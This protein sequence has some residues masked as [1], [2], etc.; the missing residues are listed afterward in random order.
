MVMPYV[1]GKTLAQWRAGESEVPPRTAAEIA[2]ELALAVA[3]AHE[4]GILHRDLKPGN[5]LLAPR[6]SVAVGDE[7][8]FIPRLTD[9][10]L[11]KSAN[12]DRQD[13]R[14]GSMIGTACYMSPEQA[15]GR[16][17][18]V[19]ARS[20]VYGLGAIL[21]EL[22][23]GVPPFREANQLR[24]IQKVLREDPPAFRS[25]KIKIPIDLEV[26]CLKCLEKAPSNRYASAQELADDLQSFLNGD[27]IR[28]RPITPIAR[29]GKWSRR[30]PTRAAMVAAGI[31]GV[32][33]LVGVSLW[34]NSRLTQLLKD[35]EFERQIARQHELE[36]R[37]RAYVT[38]VRNAKITGDQDNLGQMLKLLERHRPKD[39]EQDIRDF[40]W[41]H[42]WREFD[43]SSRQLGTHVEKA[44]SVAVTRKGDLAASGGA[45]SV[46]R[47]W[48]LPAGSLIA[49]LRGHE[50]GS[51]E[52]ISFSPNGER[53]VSA[54]ID[55][56]VRVWDM[57]TYQQLFVRGDH[58]LA[59][60]DAVYSPKGD[61][62]ASAGMDNT[63][64][65]WN[66]D[67]GESLGV[68]S[69]H[70][71]RV[72]CMAFHPTED[73]L[74]SGGGDATIRLWDWKSRCPD[75]RLEGG[76]I[77]IPDLEQ[78]PRA[79]VFEPN[80]KS[81]IAGVMKS[82]TVRFSLEK[83][84]YGNE[85][86]RRSERGN[87]LSLAWP[88]DGSLMVG[89]GNSEIRVADRLD[90]ELPGEWRRGHLH[91]VVSIATPADGSSLVSCSQ[92][93][94]VRYW[95]QFPTHSRICIAQQ[96]GAAWVDQPRTYSV[97][98]RNQFLAADFQQRELS[99][100]QMPERQLVRTFPKANEDGFAL[101]PSG[102]L[103]LIY[104]HDGKVSCFRVNDGQPAWEQQFP[105]GPNGSF[106][107]SCVIDN[108][109]MFAIIGCGN[110]LLVI[111]IQTATIMYRHSHPDKLSQ[112]LFLDR[113][114]GPLTAI[115]TCHDG[116]IRFWEVRSGKLRREHQ[117]HVGPVN[118]IA[119][120]LD[121]RM[122][123][124]GGEDRKVRVW[125]LED[126]SE[127]VA[128][129]CS[130]AP[131][132]ST[133]GFLSS[134]KILVRPNSGLSFWSIPDETEL[135][136]F[137]DCGKFGASAISPDGYQLAIPQHGW[138]RLIDGKQRIY[139]KSR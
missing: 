4:R 52:S 95:P 41:W 42:L 99:I 106:G 16:N 49:E 104:Q 68:L 82:E 116:A 63:V 55:G 127:I 29:I 51:V 124:T 109:D 74:A 62:I 35:A 123:A 75:P 103:V 139:G 85:I 17:R 97:Q 129:P 11:A 54:G 8:P 38:D 33:A 101:S 6:E 28:A 39:R 22:L 72:Y 89:L 86:D 25:F 7:P 132:P 102:R 56:T 58:E 40:A 80:G 31:L 122:I 14:T 78:I 21:Y 53:L 37:R 131:P 105:L 100:Y 138:I 32:L 44:T 83:E 96:K 113:K 65:L 50:P 108:S 136:A 12:A 18:D 66:P 126:M 98:W 57:A 112:L 130:E 67:T 81:L 71:Q 2:R 27:P 87:P 34:Y 64:R 47:I 120:S 135:L 111:S 90:P 84:S 48:S 59:V 46:I 26:I 119:L 60:L 69:G 134:S 23:T 24:T 92:D 15:E 43:E 137:P 114:T 128:L 79:L 94:N 5:V 93:G 61:V 88:R 77:Q 36:A 30:H 70:S 73:I 115:S 118:S 19:T 125:Q 1:P 3:H 45:D 121:N 9:F 20:D 10:G 13:T 133:I 76:L 91:A 110:E 117:V 107:D